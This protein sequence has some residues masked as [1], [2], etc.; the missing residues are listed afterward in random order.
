MIVT[1]IYLVCTVEAVVFALSFGILM[2]AGYIML[3]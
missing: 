2:F 1:K 3:S